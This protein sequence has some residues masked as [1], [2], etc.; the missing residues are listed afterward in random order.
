MRDKFVYT[1]QKTWESFVIETDGEQI[2]HIT[3]RGWRLPTGEFVK[4]ETMV[5]EWNGNK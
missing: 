3:F 2:K 5:T 1:N 4:D